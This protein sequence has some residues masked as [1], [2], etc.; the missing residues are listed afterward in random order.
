M[1]KRFSGVTESI[2][3]SRPSGGSRW[4]ADAAESRGEGNEGSSAFHFPT[5][6]CGFYPRPVYT[7]ACEP[8][9]PA[10]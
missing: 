10:S 3:V 1:G 6:S 2:Q 9:F 7:T 4:L 5:S 8:R